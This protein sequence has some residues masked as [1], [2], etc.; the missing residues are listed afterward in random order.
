MSWKRSI[1]RSTA[2][3][4][5]SDYAFAVAATSFAV[6]ITLLATRWLE[7]FPLLILVTPVMGSA[8][9]GVAGP[10]LVA[11]ALSGV[12]ILAATHFLA[13]PFSIPPVNAG[14]EVV[15]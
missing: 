9:R 7:D 8:L 15:R 4:A 1:A 12:A 5:N 6:V 2:P 14:D 3:P 11:T 10:G 13:D